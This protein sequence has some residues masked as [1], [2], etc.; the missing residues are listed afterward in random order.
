M[1]NKVVESRSTTEEDRKARGED[2]V[3]KK[4]SLVD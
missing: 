3:V 1:I 4:V 2:N